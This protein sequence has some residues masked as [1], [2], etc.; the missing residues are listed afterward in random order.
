VC[1]SFFVSFESL[2]QDLSAPGHPTCLLQIQTHFEHDTRSRCP[3]N[4]KPLES[5][6]PQYPYVIA[7]TGKS[8]DIADAMRAD[9][10]PIVYDYHS[11]SEQDFVYVIVNDY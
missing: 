4:Y 9:L 10:M 11:R 5:R 1:F 2:N 8:F 6:I 3:L 7:I